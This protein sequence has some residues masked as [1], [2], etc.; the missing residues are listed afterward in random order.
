MRRTVLVLVG[1]VL[2]GASAAG[3]GTPG[4]GISGK[5]VAGPT[6]PVESVPPAPG[7]APRALRATVRIR[8]VGS[9]DRATIVR[10][11]ADGRFRVR[12][13]PGTYWVRALPYAGQALPRPPPATRVRVRAARY[14][15][16]TI[17]YDTGIR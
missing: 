14:T 5:I 11:G 7:C 15:L 2:I 4:S 17:T 6:C 3:A 1:I 9:L 16:V 10:S 12:L 13:Y 8:R